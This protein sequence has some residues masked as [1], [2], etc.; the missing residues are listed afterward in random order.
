MA[1]TYHGQS[2]S[3]GERD[4][5]DI[6]GFWKTRWFWGFALMEVFFFGGGYVVAS[7]G[8]EAVGFAQAPDGFLAMGGIMGSLGIVTGVM[9]VSCIAM[10][11]W[12]RY[13]RMVERR[14]EF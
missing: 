1:T 6:V 5:R 9:W 8:T 12:F 4:Y 2:P 13:R 11:A 7:F 3:G 14:I 10:S